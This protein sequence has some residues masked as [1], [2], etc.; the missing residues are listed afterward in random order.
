MMLEALDGTSNW[1]GAGE[2]DEKQGREGVLLGLGIQA[3]P[4]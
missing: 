3:T 2:G 1:N 4:D